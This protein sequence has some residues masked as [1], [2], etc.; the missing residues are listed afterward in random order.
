MDKKRSVCFL[1]DGIAHV[2]GLADE[3]LGNQAV[4]R[5]RDVMQRR[6]N[7]SASTLTSQRTVGRR[8]WNFAHTV[9]PI[10]VLII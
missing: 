10:P 1:W 9:C 8:P 3:H 4:M 7:I 2:L 6:I 5:L